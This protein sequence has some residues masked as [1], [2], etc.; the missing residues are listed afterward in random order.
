MACGARKRIPQ[1]SKRQTTMDHYDFFVFSLD[2]QLFAFDVNRVGKVVRAMQ[3]TQLPEGPEL[4]QGI[5]DI[6]GETLPVIN[7]RRRFHLPA[8]EIA[9]DDRIV[10]VNGQRPMA[11]IADTV[12]G[13][14]ALVPEQYQSPSQLY[15][16]LE[17]Y[18]AGV[19]KHREQTILILDIKV[20]DN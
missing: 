20:L 19:G 13:V 8:R 15:P 16:G 3:L 2:G 6:R 9:L 10:I 7:I 14:L 1:T 11:F 12:I 5:I 4:V 17:R 18:L